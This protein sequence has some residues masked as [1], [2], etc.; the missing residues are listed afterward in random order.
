MPDS[1]NTRDATSSACFRI[2]GEMPASL[3]TEIA[4]LGLSCGR[5][6][7]QPSGLEKARISPSGMHLR[8]ISLRFTALTSRVQLTFRARAE[9][10]KFRGGRL[11]IRGMEEKRND[12]P[13]TFSVYLW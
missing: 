7:A 9:S 13:V 4:T 8:S 2:V 10:R 6:L 5:L 11:Q 3:K 1:S 12:A